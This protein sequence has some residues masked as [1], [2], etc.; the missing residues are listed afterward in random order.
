FSRKVVSLLGEL[1][2][3][4][5]SFFRDGKLKR[6]AVGR[7]AVSEVPIRSVVIVT[8]VLDRDLVMRWIR[9][10][11]IEFELHHR[12][13]CAICRRGRET[14][15]QQEHSGPDYDFHHE[16]ELCQKRAYRPTAWRRSVAAVC[17]SQMAIASASAAS[18]GC[19]ISWSRNRRATMSCTCSFSAFPYPTTADLMLRGAYSLTCSPCDAAASIA[20]PRACPSL[21]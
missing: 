18:A 3:I 15:Q 11:E 8:V 2:N 19:G 5:A 4:M 21:S 20:T 1:E 14:S 17:R 6:R 9:S 13:G 12:A 16:Q 10:R 7:S